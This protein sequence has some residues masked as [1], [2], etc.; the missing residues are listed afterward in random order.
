MDYT[1]LPVEQVAQSRQQVQNM[2]VARV[3]MANDEHMSP[4][5]VF[6]SANSPYATSFPSV[7]DQIDDRLSDLPA[8]LFVDH[9]VFSAWD[10]ECERIFPLLPFLSRTLRSSPDKNGC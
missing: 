5:V 9:S 4:H 2:F 7:F 6:H 10:R 8:L 1:V 3:G